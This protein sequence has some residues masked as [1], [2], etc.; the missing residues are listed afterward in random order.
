MFKF[1]GLSVGV[2]SSESSNLAQRIAALASDVT[3]TTGGQMRRLEWADAL[4]GVAGC[5][6]GGPAQ[7]HAARRGSGSSSAILRCSWPPHATVFTATPA[8]SL[9]LVCCSVRPGIYIPSRQ[10]QPV[11]S[12]C[13]ED[14]QP[15]RRPVGRAA[16]HLPA[17]CLAGSLHAAFL[18][19]LHLF[20]FLLTPRSSGCQLLLTGCP[21]V[22][23]TLLQVIRRPLHFAIVDEAD[24]LLIGKPGRANSDV[25][26]FNCHVLQFA[27]ADEATPN[28]LLL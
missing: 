14:R 27:S 3:Y 15:I 12:G 5:M 7:R 4:A 9:F 22:P 23:P 28:S 19:F 20:S 1:L 18:L 6:G 17:C 16:L 21:I 10:H 13:G 11:S 8:R 2:L 26:T 25:A 24:S